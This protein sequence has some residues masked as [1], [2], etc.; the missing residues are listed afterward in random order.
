[1][2]GAGTP[3]NTGR[4]SAAKACSHDVDSGRSPTV[5]DVVARNR[6][7][8]GHL[9]D[10]LSS[11][12]SSTLAM[13]LAS[14]GLPTSISDSFSID[15]VSGAMSGNLASVGDGV[16]HLLTVLNSNV[17]DLSLI[18]EPVYRC[19]A[20]QLRSSAHHVCQLSEP[21]LWLMLRVLDCRHSI[22]AFIDMGMSQYLVHG[23]I[24]Q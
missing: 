19:L 23:L 4:W 14:S 8:M 9:I 12:N 5:A 3:V 18:V 17:T 16:F 10:A 2:T 22:Q 11:C 7:V 20:G 21:L 1:M 24:N 13:L 15:P 6:S